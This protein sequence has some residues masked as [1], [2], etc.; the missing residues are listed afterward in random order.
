M[1]KRLRSER[2]RMRLT[3]T[4]VAEYIGITQAS[5]STIECGVRSG[6]AWIWEKLERLFRVDR[7]LLRENS[8]DN[9]GIRSVGRNA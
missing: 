3:Q 1:R 6:R 9:N 4:E 2:I 7:R 8:E 5:Y